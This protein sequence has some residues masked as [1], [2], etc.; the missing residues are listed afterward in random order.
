VPLY[1]VAEATYLIRKCGPVIGII[2][3]PSNPP[4]T[5][6]VSVSISTRST[7]LM[8]DAS[9]P[10]AGAESIDDTYETAAAKR[11]YV[12]RACDLCKRKK[13]KCDGEEVCKIDHIP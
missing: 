12:T 4:H 5:F 9:E 1:R 11:K 10:N 8:D 7:E 6:A 3:S 2:T 13:V